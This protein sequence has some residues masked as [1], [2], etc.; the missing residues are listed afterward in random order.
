MREMEE[1][2]FRPKWRLFQAVTPI[3]RRDRQQTQW[4]K[5]R[6]IGPSSC[7]L[8]HLH[9]IDTAQ[10]TDLGYR[11]RM[12][13]NPFRGHQRSATDTALVVVAVVAT[14]AVIVWALLA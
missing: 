12:G 7:V 5:V 6:R 1:P 2:L 10:R 4:P 9:L 3:E 8:S 14:I 13:F 11:F